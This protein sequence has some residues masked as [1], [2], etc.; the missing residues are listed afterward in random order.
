MD[1]S[2]SLTVGGRKEDKDDLPI[3]LV[4]LDEQNQTS[5]NHKANVL[6]VEGRLKWLLRALLATALAARK[7]VLR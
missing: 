1:G 5:L 6:F 7:L 3:E 2:T 4:Y